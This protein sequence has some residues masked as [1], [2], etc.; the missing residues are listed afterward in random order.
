[1]K[2]NLMLLVLAA[3]CGGIA[4]AFGAGLLLVDDGRFWPGPPLPGPRPPPWP[5]PHPVRPHVFAPLE[6]SYV[7]VNTRIADQVAVTA[8]DQEFYNPNAARLE[9]TFLFPVPKGAHLDKFTL[10]ID[11]RQA[12]AELLSADKA[13]RIYEDI[14]RRARDPALLEYA[15]QDVFKVRVFP[16]EPGSHRRITLRYSELLKSENGLVSYLLP[17]NPAHFSAA[18]VKSVSVKVELESKRPLKTIYSPTHAVELKRRSP[19]SALAGYEASNVV[20]D[21]D[22]ALYFAPEKDELGVNLLASR[23]GGEDGYFLLLASPGLDVKEEQVMAKDVVFVLDTSGSMA[24]PKIEQAKKALRFCVENLNEGDRFELVRFSTEVEPLFGHL[25]AASAANRSRAEEFIRDLRAN[26]GTDIDGA[27]AKA[28]ALAPGA[29]GGKAEG[30]Q[31]ESAAQDQARPFAVIFLTD[32]QPTVGTTD[33]EQ[34]VA[35]VKRGSGGRAHVFCF[36]IGGDVNTRLLDRITEVTRAS[37][38]YVLPEEDIEV[39]V[40][41]FYAK[42]KAPVLANPT[43]RFTGDVRVRQLYP[44]SLPDLF[45]G[46]QLVLAGRYSGHGPSAVIVEGSVRGGSRQY[47][48]EVN[49]PEAAAENEFIPRLWATRRVGWLLDEIRLHG[50]NAELRDEVTELARKYGIVTP[51][52]AY[53]IMEDETRR[54]V[55]PPLRVMRELESDRFASAA[56]ARTWKEFTSQYAGEAAVADAGASL[57]LKSASAPAVA[58]AQSDVAFRRRYGV[59]S[60]AAPAPTAAGGMGGFGGGGGAPPATVGPGGAGGLTINAAPAADAAPERVVQYAQQT[61]FVAGKSFFWNGQ[62]WVDSAL[63]KNPGAKRVRLEFAS[64]DYFA[65]LERNPQARPWLAL[66]G[67]VQFVLDNTVYEVEEK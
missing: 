54:D 53:L 61:R 19:S 40:S 3:L 46:E 11:G 20:P 16:I 4:P 60:P 13:S 44:G 66:G 49:F 14:V 47:T 2:K 32:G 17:L 25:V 41:N 27:L 26:G 5:T 10:E 7:K 24:G 58:R 31:P 62:Q 9:G 36:G 35:A 43:V 42:I 55:P 65:F 56:A 18:P 38:Q 39:K 8:V 22:F 6:V 52:T 37:S 67:N 33:E 12:E 63:Q 15:G 57:A 59:A 21:A 64:L 30:L 29:Q 50:E 23:M 45:K 28:L 48:Y 1:M 51:Y 34:I